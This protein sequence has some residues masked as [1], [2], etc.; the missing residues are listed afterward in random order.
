MLLSFQCF[1]FSWLCFGLT[2]F[3]CMTHQVFFFS[4]LGVFAKAWTIER[5]RSTE[6]QAEYSAHTAVK[7][8]QAS[9]WTDPCPTVRPPWSEP[10]MRK[11]S[12]KSSPRVD[13]LLC[14]EHCHSPT[15]SLSAD[16]CAAY[17]KFAYLY[18]HW[19]LF[20]SWVHDGFSIEN[21][22]CWS[23]YSLYSNVSRFFLSFTEA[24]H[25]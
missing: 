22:T 19:S 18:F 13:L 20:Q 15:E 5:P 1:S 12:I 6:I 16:D 24:F 7:C 4:F 23:W 21:G 9:G 14:S 10:T 17:Q 11:S 2:I 8:A 3:F 25:T